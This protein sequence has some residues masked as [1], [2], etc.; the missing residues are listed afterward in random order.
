MERAVSGERSRISRGM[1]EGLWDGDALARA[2]VLGE[3]SQGLL[4]RGPVVVQ[5][6][7]ATITNNGRRVDIFEALTLG[8][9]KCNDLA[10][11]F[12]VLKTKPFL[13]V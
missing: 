7:G 3:F 10:E 6:F 13:A 1:E 12:F 4:E 2:V 5:F 9:F 11:G 8:L